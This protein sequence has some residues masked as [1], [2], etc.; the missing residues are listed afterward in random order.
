MTVLEQ[1]QDEKRRISERLDRLAPQVDKLRS[2]FAELETA[3]AVM[4]RLG[5]AETTVVPDAAEAP[6][7]NAGA[8]R[9]RGRPPR[10][11][12]E[13]RSSASAA[14]KQPS[15]LSSATLRVLHEGPRNL[16]GV[17]DALAAEGIHAR[18]PHVAKSLAGH[19]HH[20]RVR[21]IN[22]TWFLVE[23]AVPVMDQAAE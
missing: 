23:G 18:A 11:A 7:S 1:I 15:E 16:A 3:E 14:A 10:R 6:A 12:G 17:V 22:D 4:R 8:P 13:S 5:G 19:E 21:R 9:R 20:G 2:E